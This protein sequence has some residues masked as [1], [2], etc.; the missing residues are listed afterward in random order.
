MSKP[1]I[2]FYLRK[3]DIS[4]NR[5]PLVIPSE[6][7]FH[8]SGISKH[9]PTPYELYIRKLK[10]D[11]DSTTEIVSITFNDTEYDKTVKNTIEQSPNFIRWCVQKNDS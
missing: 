6:S 3:R 11:Y 4:Q 10:S 2:Q 5:P 7:E 9:D 8:S 1:Y